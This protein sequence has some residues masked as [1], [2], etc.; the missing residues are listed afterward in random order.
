MRVPVSSTELRGLA[1]NGQTAVGISYGALGIATI[2]RKSTGL[3]SVHEVQDLS[4]DTDT[5]TRY[6]SLYL[7][8]TSGVLLVS[9]NQYH[10][11]I[12]KE[13]VRKRN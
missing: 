13:V 2:A 8:C 3:V 7:R 11:G 1:G 5:C 9:P 10:N 6:A 12:R 4:T